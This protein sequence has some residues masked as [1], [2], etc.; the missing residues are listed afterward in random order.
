M[1]TESL[2]A[3]F[4]AEVRVI[5]ELDEASWPIAAT[6]AKLDYAQKTDV[7]VVCPGRAAF[8][9]QISL[10]PKSIGAQHRLETRGVTPLAV[11]ELD[12]AGLTAPEFV[13][14]ALC[15]RQLCSDRLA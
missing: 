1:S 10:G 11:T 5:N 12:S 13:C 7:R 15:S 8:N 2:L 6:G 4:Q 14:Q 9:L 3:G